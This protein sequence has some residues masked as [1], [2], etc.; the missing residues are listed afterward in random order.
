MLT[1]PQICVLLHQATP[2]DLTATLTDENGDP[3]VGKTVSFSVDA[4]AVGDAVTDASGV[5]TIPNYDVSG[6]SIGDHEVDA[7]FTAPDDACDYLSTNGVGNLGAT[8]VFIGFQQPINADGTSQFGGRTIPV[9]IKLADANGQPVTDAEAHVFF[10]FGTPALIGTD[11]E[12]VA[13]TNGDTGNLM[14]YDPGANQYIFNWDIAGLAN[15]TYY[16]WVDL[17]EGACGDQHSVIVTMKKK[18]SK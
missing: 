13:N 6:L 5:A 8:Y 10:N 7:T 1:V 18:G 11:A 14:R 9:K 16:V 2:V 15:G 3:V 17:G 12:P 4:N